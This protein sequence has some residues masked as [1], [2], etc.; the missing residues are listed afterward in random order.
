[1]LGY[2]NDPQY[3]VYYNHGFLRG[4]GKFSAVEIIL[5]LLPLFI[6]YTL[7][8]FNRPSSTERLSYCTTYPEETTPI[9]RWVYR[10]GINI[11][12]YPLWKKNWI[13]I[14]PLIYIYY[15]FNQCYCSLVKLK[16]VFISCFTLGSRTALTVCS[17]TQITNGDLKNLT[18][19][20]ISYI[21]HY[22]FLPTSDLGLY[23][24]YCYQNAISSHSNRAE[25]R[26]FYIYHSLLSIWLMK[27][28]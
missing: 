22:H 25:G 17:R 18:K 10:K 20:Y 26:W 21:N 14:Q 4:S 3:S 2:S 8:W 11:F 7:R 15:I 12:S 9:I 5:R 28:T 16:L 19:I 13:W 27:I 1:M 24:K 23:V 6:F